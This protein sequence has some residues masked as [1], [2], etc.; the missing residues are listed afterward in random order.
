MAETGHLVLKKERNIR[1][2]EYLV[3]EKLLLVRVRV[4]EC[5]S[6]E[7]KLLFFFLMVGVWNM[8]M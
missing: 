5:Y 4:S 6:K 8:E 1:I 2:S 7:E 3:S